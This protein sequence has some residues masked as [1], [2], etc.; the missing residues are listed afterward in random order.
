[1]AAPWRQL[2]AIA[3]AAAGCAVLGAP[4]AAAAATVSPLPESDYTTR[5]AC[6][7]PEPG[8]VACMALQLVPLTA[9][10]RAHRHPLGIAS[11]VVPASP[12]PTAGSFGLRPQDLHSAYGLPTSAPSAQTIAVVDA[13]NDP[14]AETDLAAYDEAFGLPECTTGNGCLQQVNEEGA[15]SPLPFPS[16]AAA[17]QAAEEGT[18]AERAEAERAVGWDLEISL[19]V[20]AAHAT[21]QSCHILLVEARS[22]RTSDMFAAESAAETAGAQEISNSWGGPEPG[23]SPEFD[24]T[25]P[26]T[27]A[28]TVIT[29]SAGDSGYLDWDSEGEQGFANY[30]ATSPHVVSVG[31]TRLTLGA[32]G[33]WAGE[34][35]WNGNGAGGGGCSVEQRAPYWQ[36]EVADWA[37]VGCG[38]RRAVADVSADA[39]PYTGI[40]VYDASPACKTAYEEGGLEVTV[41]WCTIG[42]TSLSSPLVAAVFALAGGSGG[43]SFPAR[44]LYENAAAS[45]GSLHDVTQGSNGPCAS[46][47]NILTGLS[48][49]S[50]GEEAQG[51]SEHLI[52]LA[53]TG[54]DGPSGVGTPAGTAAFLP[55]G[56]PEAPPSTP[57][58]G[59]GLQIPPGGTIPPRPGQGA[60]PPAP[61]HLLGLALTIRALVALNRARPHASQVGFTYTLSATA[62]VR[63]ALARRVRHHRHSSWRTVGSAFT[64]AAAIG[65]NSGHLL[66]HALLGRGLYQLTVTPLGGSGRSIHFQIG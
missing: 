59:G 23:A 21:C 41:H 64:V 26:F 17:L 57:P 28:H 27:H 15:T 37:A 3:A 58:A 51:C 1:M 66:S 9:Q 44:T 36:K 65:H 50:V 38:G 35:I 33:S 29:A 40:A 2:R 55:T 14:H 61:A 60:G 30:P 19:D 56:K 12:S 62:P 8:R 34:S 16:S 4:S 7:A 13:Y 5:A 18:A 32:G 43:V 47:Y 63:I 39:D 52:C 31:G 24:A 53:G 48:G 6:A 22:A 49:C 20:E 42:G 11:A 45:P 10:A 54:Y 46:P 25:S